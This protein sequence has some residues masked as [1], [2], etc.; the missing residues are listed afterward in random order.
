MTQREVEAALG[1]PG[2][3][4]DDPSV[5]GTDPVDVPFPYLHAEAYSEPKMT[6]GLPGCY[7][8]P[9]CEWKSWPGDRFMIEVAFGECGGAT[10]VYLLGADPVPPRRKTVLERIRAKLGW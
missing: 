3:D 8:R 9:P 1:R 10:G 2:L 5:R 6:W 4:P 7:E